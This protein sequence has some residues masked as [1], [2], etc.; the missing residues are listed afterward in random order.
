MAVN[1]CEKLFGVV[2]TKDIVPSTACMG[3][4]GD[5]VNAGDEL[6]IVHLD[7]VFVPR[8]HVEVPMVTWFLEFAIRNVGNKQDAVVTVINFN[9]ISPARKTSEV[10]QRLAKIF[11]FRISGPIKMMDGLKRASNTA[12][13]PGMLQKIH[14]YVLCSKRIAI[15]PAS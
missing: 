6:A 4:F 9:K 8:T 14:Y 7:Q 12:Q 2:L 1:I 11:A 10:K 13:I 5:G 3:I 15:Y